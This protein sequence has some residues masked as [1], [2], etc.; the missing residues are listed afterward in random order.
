[1]DPVRRGLLF[2]HLAKLVGISVEEVGATLRKLAASAGGGGPKLATERQEGNDEIRNL[3]FES[4]SNF[5]IQNGELETRNSK[6]EKVDV[7]QLKGLAAAEGWVIGALLVVPGIYLKV[8]D[9]VSLN[10]FM[11]FRRLAEV[12]I[13]YMESHEDPSECTLVGLTTQIES[14]GG[15][16]ELVRQ[17]IELEKKT[18][19]WLDPQ[20]SPMHNKMLK[21]A[22]DDRGVSL[23]GVIRDSLEQLREER[24]DEDPGVMADLGPTGGGGGELV[25]G[26]A[27]ALAALQGFI[28]KKAQKGGG[29]GNVGLG[30]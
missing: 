25:D 23:E 14:G 17:A 6:L 7:R 24:G 19:D 9:E 27:A 22:A 2:S 15:D 28:A 21:H 30:R 11:T 3:K 26:D 13:E 10:L 1:M 4:N 20:F 18:S 5:E 8:R 29:L 12:V 16:Q